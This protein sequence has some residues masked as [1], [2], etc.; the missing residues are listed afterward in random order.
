ML[1]IAPLNFKGS[2]HSLKNADLTAHQILSNFC[3]I[4]SK[5]KLFIFVEFF[6]SLSYLL[7]DFQVV[8]GNHRSTTRSITFDQSMIGS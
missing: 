1:P 7:S 2:D 6:R 5:Y 3:Q 8:I 4:F